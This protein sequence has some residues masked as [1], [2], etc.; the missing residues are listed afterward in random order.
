MED[1]HIWRSKEKPKDTYYDDWYDQTTDTK[2][3]LT[4]VLNKTDYEYLYESAREITKRL[5]WNK[6]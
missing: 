6:W 3:E 2:E 5:W 1:N 4:Q